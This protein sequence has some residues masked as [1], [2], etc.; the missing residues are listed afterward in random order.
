MGKE[1]GIQNAGRNALAMP[2]VFCTRTNVGKGWTGSKVVRIPGTKNIIIE[3]ARPFDTGLPT[4]F[5]DTF[6]VDSVTITQD[7]VGK[8]IGVAFFVEYKADDG[9]LSAIQR[10]FLKA[11][12]QLGARAGVARSADEAVSIA[13]GHAHDAL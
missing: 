4:G 2:G 5:S 13:K 12:R 11:M 10:A 3:N 8:P 9:T 1:H 6:G 7:M